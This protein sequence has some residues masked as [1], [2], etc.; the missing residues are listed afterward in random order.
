MKISIRLT[1]ALLSLLLVCSLLVSVL[2][3]PAMA[4]APAEK[5]SDEQ[6]RTSSEIT[7]SDGRVLT[8]LGASWYCNESGLFA[9]MG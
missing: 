3:T 4:A 5:L 7:L 2:A 1:T 6:S 9:V 8:A